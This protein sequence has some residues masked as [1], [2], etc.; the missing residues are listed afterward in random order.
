MLE[1]LPKEMLGIFF[2][3]MV[4]VKHVEMSHDGLVW[5]IPPVFWKQTAKKTSWNFHKCGEIART[6]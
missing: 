4:V 1:P 6:P 2:P 5:E 3:N